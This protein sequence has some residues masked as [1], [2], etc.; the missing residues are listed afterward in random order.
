MET[1]VNLTQK[2][3]T[4]E[5]SSLKW[6]R[7]LLACGVVSGPF[8]YVI[9]I[10][11]IFT[12]PGFDIR[13]HAISLLSLGDLGW[14][15]ISN[16][17]VT[18]LL[19]IPKAQLAIAPAFLCAVGIKRLLRSARAGT[20]APILIGLYGL[21]MIVGGIFHPDPGL[22]FP[23]GAPAGMP[24]SMR[25]HAAI[26]SLGFYTAFLALIAV[27]FV[28]ARRFASMKQTGWMVYCIAT[29][30]ICPVLIVLGSTIWTLAGLFFAVAGLF[31]FGMVSVVAAHLRTELS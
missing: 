31:A 16:F 7:A 28:F 14:I 1:Q 17:I 29:G 27:S 6:T 13:R 3:N 18:G 26:H 9:A 24:A 21:G 22:S 19:A 10:I 5:T 2:V 11:Q 4:Q 30:L 23:P 25:G 15:Q 12:R 20:W 8:F